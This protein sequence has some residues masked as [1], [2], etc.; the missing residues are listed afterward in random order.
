MK[1]KIL[2]LVAILGLVLVFNPAETMAEYGDIIINNK[3]GA[4]RKADVKDVLF[5]HWF[6]IIR[7]KCKACHESIFLLKSGVNPT[8]M[9]K[10]DAGENC[11][12]CHN[13]EIAETT[14]RCEKCHLQEPGWDKGPVQHSKKIVPGQIE[15]Q[16][17]VQE[18]IRKKN[19]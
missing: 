2:T 10:I 5:P 6:H 12:K 9:K 4:M 11:G 15:K 8:D 1:Q 3:A 18:E 19:K 13:G 17:T 16:I 14:E 7:F